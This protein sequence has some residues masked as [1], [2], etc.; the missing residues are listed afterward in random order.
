[1]KAEGKVFI[2]CKQA[3]YL[4]TLKQEGKLGA[5]QRFGLWLHLLYCSI[6]RLFFSQM[7]A[8]EKAGKHFSEAEGINLSAESKQR[9]AQSLH[10]EINGN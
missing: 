8:L 5:L 2:N 6:C 4:H 1:M 7:D 10:N 3:T 9:I